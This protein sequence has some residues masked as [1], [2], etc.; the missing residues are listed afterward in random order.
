M[1]TTGRIVSVGATGGAGFATAIW[2]LPVR[3]LPRASVPVTV[4]RQV[5]G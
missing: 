5:P 3:A 4:T 2:A 1:A